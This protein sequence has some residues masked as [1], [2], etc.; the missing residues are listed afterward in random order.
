MDLTALARL[1]PPCALR[2]ATGVPCP[3]C[4]TTRGALRLLAG[5][6]FG[7][8]AMNP[9]VFLGLLAGA[10]YLVWGLVAELRTG[11]WPHLPALPRRPV[12]AILAG[13]VLLNWLYVVRHEGFF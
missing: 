7:A 3:S 1:L 10:A 13:L 9:G 6:P 12:A 8:V 2:L 4:G 5:D 11:R